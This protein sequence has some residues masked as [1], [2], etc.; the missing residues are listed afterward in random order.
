MTGAEYVGTWV[1][2]R[3]RS[4]SSTGASEPGH[5]PDELADMMKVAAYEND[6]MN[7]AIAACDQWI[8][9]DPTGYAEF[10]GRVSAHSLALP[11]ITARAEAVTRRYSD[12]AAAINQ[13]D[14]A[15]P[16][17]ELIA[18]RKGLAD[19][20][21]EFRR[22]GHC[23][24]PSYPAQPQPTAPD[25]ALQAY[26]A[27]D[28]AARPIDQAASAVAEAAKG[29]VQSRVPWVIAGV[30]ATVAVVGLLRR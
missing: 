10:S 13:A 30:A 23:T 12:I 4:S 14:V 24:P 21:G 17:A 6:Q 11:P 3:R 8:H 15:A 5:S 7:A 26:Q 2:V 1:P 16:Y 9:T 29:V 20:D 22:G 27:A 25:P 18:W 28:A 19:L